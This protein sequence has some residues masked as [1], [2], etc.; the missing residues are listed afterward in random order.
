ANVRKQAVQLG[1]CIRQAEEYFRASSHVGLPT[2]PLLL[3]YGAM[4][5]TKALTLLRL[6]GNH[7]FDG[8]RKSNRH[9]HHGLDL[10]GQAKPPGKEDRSDTFFRSIE[11]R[12]HTEGNP[13]SPW[14]HFGL[15]YLSLRPPAAR[16]PIELVVQ[17]IPHSPRELDGTARAFVEKKP[18][19]S[20]AT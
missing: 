1:Y 4:S 11:C 14:G 18:L 12:C 19:D 8:L 13:P 17:N 2:R 10:V 6:D 9:N 7:S 5:L 16:L 3:Y 20:L 15:F